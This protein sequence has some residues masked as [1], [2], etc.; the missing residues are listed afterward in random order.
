MISDVG[1]LLADFCRV[2][3]IAGFA[4]TDR[5]I[6]H[7]TLPAPHKSSRLPA[8]KQAAYVFSVPGP[9]PLVLKVGKVGPNSNER[10]QFQHY[11]PGSAGSNLA[12]SLLHAPEHWQ[13][14]AIVALDE[15]SVGDWIKQHTDRENFLIPEEGG[16]FLLSLLEVFLQCRLR[17]MFEG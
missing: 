3:A 15:S 4:V 1:A 5:D 8:G 12:K 16:R 2:A 6:V 13:R 9:S 11:N 7:E 17:P 14:L 10:Y